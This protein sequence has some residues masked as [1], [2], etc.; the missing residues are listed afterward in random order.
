MGVLLS[1]KQKQAIWKRFA[2]HAFSPERRAKLS[3]AAKVNLAIYREKH[4]KKE[5]L[6]KSTD[7]Y[8]AQGRIPIKHD[9]N[10]H[11]GY[12]RLFGSW[13]NAIRL[14]GF[15][16]NPLIFSYKFT[17]EDGHP[18]DSF[19]EKI[20]DDWL[21][22]HH[23]THER[24]VRYGNTKMT[25]DFF[26]RPNTVLEFFGLAGVQKSYDEIIKRKRKLCRKLNLKLIEVYAKDIFPRNTLPR[27]LRF[28]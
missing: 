13:N 3:R 27:L 17:A 7:F 24:S 28:M 6:D 9:F 18:C 23:I 12:K 21:Y 5:L 19:T 14:A 16:P 11:R 8:E 2:E 26:I 25:A 22:K 10:M 4:T 1:R 15:K 20:I